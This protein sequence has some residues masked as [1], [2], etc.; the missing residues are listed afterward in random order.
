MELLMSTNPIVLLW[1][2][3]ESQMYEI[4]K[5][6]IVSF[7]EQIVFSANTLVEGQATSLKVTPA[8]EAVAKLFADSEGAIYVPYGKS[9]ISIVEKNQKYQIVQINPFTEVLDKHGPVSNSFMRAASQAHDVGI[10]SLTPVE[11][12]FFL[13]RGLERVSFSPTNVEYHGKGPVFSPSNNN[14][15]FSLQLNSKKP[16]N[17]IFK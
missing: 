3:I 4:N 2:D 15:K 6:Q 9:F 7:D 14:A 10:K 16:L 13:P 12:H 17:K 1:K 5:S 11:Y 8:L